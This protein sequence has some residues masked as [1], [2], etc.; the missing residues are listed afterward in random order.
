MY[1]KIFSKLNEVRGDKKK[2]SEPYSTYGEEVFFVGD[3]EIR[4][5]WKYFTKRS[6][7]KP[8]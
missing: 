3:E 8:Y 4:Q 6:E 2:T 7:Q 1:F 5:F